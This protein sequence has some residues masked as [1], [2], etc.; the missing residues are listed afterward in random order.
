MEHSTVAFSYK[1]K[2]LIM[3]L[4]PKCFNKTL[5]SSTISRKAESYTH[6]EVYLYLMMKGIKE[7]SNFF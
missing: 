3:E 5:E 2:K 4:S 1:I 7:I 6:S